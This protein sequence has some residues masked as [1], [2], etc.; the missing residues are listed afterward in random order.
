MRKV[1]VIGVGGIG[2]FLVQY[3]DKVNLYN[4]DIADPDR[5]E[6]KN[7]PYQNFSGDIGELKVIS[8][9]KRFKSI[10]TA[11]Q[12]PVLTEFQ[13]QGY[14]LVV[15]CVDNLDAR[16]LLYRSKVPW[17]DLRAQGRNCVLISY[18]MENHEEVLQ[19]EEGSFSCQGD[20]DGSNSGIHWM[21]VVAAGM[22]AQWIQ[23][24]FNDE[25]VCKFKVVNI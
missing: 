16:R 20:W 2:S 12:F 14:D 13:I 3:L 11:H 4:I 1:L 6:K 8:M 22:G 24:W 23:R 9:I 10:K 18:E 25:D 5:V 19:G 17:L 21:Q 15:C 7:I